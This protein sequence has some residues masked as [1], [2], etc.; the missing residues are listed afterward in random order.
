MS[1]VDVGR[2]ILSVSYIL[3]RRISRQVSRFKGRS[4]WVSTVRLSEGAEKATE[5][6]C[7]RH[8]R[9][10]GRVD[11]FLVNGYTGDELRV[12]VHRGAAVRELLLL[13]PARSDT[14]SSRIVPVAS[15]DAVRQSLLELDLASDDESRSDDHSHQALPISA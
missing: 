14:D 10:Q 4:A 8:L 9:N 13:C 5:E 12:D 7:K 15:V 3:T 11:P 6:L 1:S 2:R